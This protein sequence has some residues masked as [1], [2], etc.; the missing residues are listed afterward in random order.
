[1]GQH[2]INGALK[3]LYIYY[4]YYNNVQVIYVMVFEFNS[5]SKWRLQI[6]YTMNLVYYYIWKTV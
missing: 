1:M 5:R 3:K 4:S 6:D 2:N